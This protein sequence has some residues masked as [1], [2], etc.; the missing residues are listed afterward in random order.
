MDWC[1]TC[2]SWVP[3]I[4][5]TATFFPTNVPQEDNIIDVHGHLFFSF[6]SYQLFKS[7]ALFS[8]LGTCFCLYWRPLFFTGIDLEKYESSS[9]AGGIFSTYFWAVLT[10]LEATQLALYIAIAIV[11]LNCFLPHYC[12]WFYLRF[13]GIPNIVVFFFC[14]FGAIM[15]RACVMIYFGQIQLF[16]SLKCLSVFQNLSYEKGEDLLFIIILYLRQHFVAHSHIQ[17]RIPNC[18]DFVL[19]SCISYWLG[20]FFKGRVI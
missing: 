20:F 4:V 2:T 7:W 12:S 14:A 13:A 17:S 8:F 1:L 16:F 5:L 15:I 18:T 19:I 3:C 11:L 10:M 9:C 6:F